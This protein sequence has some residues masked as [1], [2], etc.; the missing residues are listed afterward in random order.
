MATQEE[1]MLDSF[2]V[3]GESSISSEFSNNKP[4]QFAFRLSNKIQLSGVWD[5]ALTSIHIPHTFRTDF[6]Q[7]DRFIRIYHS[8]AKKYNLDSPINSTSHMT[9][10]RP[11]LDIDIGH[12]D[13]DHPKLVDKLTIYINDFMR[14][15]TNEAETVTG[16]FDN[17][18]FDGLLFTFDL[19]HNKNCI[20]Q[21]YVA[22]NIPRVL[23]W[24][25]GF[26]K[27]FFKIDSKSSTVST[28]HYANADSQYSSHLDYA[29]I[30]SNIVAPTH[31]C[32]QKSNLLRIVPITCKFG[33]VMDLNFTNPM[34]IQLNTTKLDL[35]K[36][37]ICNSLGEIFKTH[38]GKTFITL[39]FRKKYL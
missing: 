18:G 32:S 11:Y 7:N 19:I 8:S 29:Y 25:L 9:A 12:F 6:E 4:C 35:I 34:Y 22:V 10:S 2:Y 26:T 30:Y 15:I 5:V 14:N 38:I 16:N 3:Y 28:K 36:I 17:K 31:I 1:G 27:T 37:D 39:H 24:V 13:L 20:T 23:A 21:K 33:H